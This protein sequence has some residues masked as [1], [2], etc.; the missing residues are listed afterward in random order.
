M[1]KAGVRR[2]LDLGCGSGRHAV[3]LAKKGFDVYSM[4]ISEEGCR[5]TREWL[6][7]SKLHA[8]VKKASC[9]RKFPFKDGY[10]DALISTQ[11]IHHNYIAKVRF[12]ISEIHRVLKPGGFVFVSVAAKKAG[13]FARK[14]RFVARHTYLPLDGDEKG[15]PHYIY[16]IPRMRNDFS[17][18]RIIRVYKDERFHYVLFGIKKSQ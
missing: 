8:V 3:L 2:I 1:K 13:Y 17:G 9:Y 6:R 12:C 14:A 5:L 4:D 18:F 11:V 10:F 16:D 7:K 15:V